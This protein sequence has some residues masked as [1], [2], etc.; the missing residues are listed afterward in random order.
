MQSFIPVASDSPD[1]LKKGSSDL[2][3]RIAVAV[4][5]L[6]LLAAILYF[7]GLFAEITVS[8]IHLLCVQEILNAVSSFSTPFR[9]ISYGFPLLLLPAFAALGGPAGAGSLL[10]FGVMLVFIVLILSHRKAE[11]G[12]FTILPML[13]PG[14][15]FTSIYELLLIPEKPIS[16]F[17]LLVALGCAVVTDT[18]AYL[19]GFLLGRHKL[20][21]R[22]SPHKTVEGAL[23]GLL[24][25]ALYVF[26]IGSQTQSLFGVRLENLQYVAL[27]IL[28]S[29]FSQFGD[30]AAS[31]LKR[32]F[33]IKDF[34]RILGPHGGLLDRLDSMLF[35]AP[36]ANLF[37]Q[38]CIALG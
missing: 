36:I 19:G 26:A 23:C 38:L 1:S 12:I 4:P 31:Y 30:L 24:F 14:L 10:T 27:G 3:I 20:I 28:L 29:I 35:L 7:H 17:L 6:M 21:E 2:L 33:G 16:Q 9:A 37:Y 8:F 25:G 32:S 15:F 13:Y 18:F 11:D 22:V 34:G 5:A